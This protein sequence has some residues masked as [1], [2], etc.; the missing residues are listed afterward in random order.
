MI[1]DKLLARRPA[2]GSARSALLRSGF[3]Q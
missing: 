1:Q 3:V 2:T